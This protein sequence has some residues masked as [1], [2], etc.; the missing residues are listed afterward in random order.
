MR[1]ILALAVVAALVAGCGGGDDLAGELTGAVAIVSAPSDAIT[2]VGRDV[3]GSVSSQ[4][5]E[6]RLEV[7]QIAPGR[8]EVLVPYGD[9]PDL[10]EPVRVV[11][12]PLGRGGVG[13][14]LPAGD[15]ILV[16]V[17]TLLDPTRQGVRFA[18]RL[19]ALRDGVVTAADWSDEA[20]ARLAALLDG[21]ADP[22]ALLAE[23][24]RALADDGLGRE[25]TARQRELV[26]TVTG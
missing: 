25:L 17:T 2:L 14:L 21:V 4:N 9:V 8:A 1:R 15:R 3:S 24:V 11:R 19:V 18:G 23:T 13:A 6:A 22:G 5:A 10:E 20:T 16:V 26:A 12:D 7:L